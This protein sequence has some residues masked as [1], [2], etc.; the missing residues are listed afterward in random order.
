MLLALVRREPVHAASHL[1]QPRQLA[2]GARGEPRAR[3][4]GARCARRGHGAAGAADADRER[5]ARNDRR[6]GGRV[7]GAVAFPLLSVLVPSTLP[8]ASQPTLDLRVLGWR[9]CSRRSPALGFGLIPALRT[10]GRA[11]IDAL[12]A[13]ALRRRSSDNGAVLLVPSKSRCRSYCSSLPG[14]LIRAYAARAGRRSWLQD[15]A[16]VLTLR[17]VLPKPKYDSAYTR[18]QFYSAVLARCGGCRACRARRTPA[19]LPMVM[20]GGII[21]RVITPGQEVQR[22]RRLPG[23]PSLRD[24]AVLSARLGIP[25]HEGP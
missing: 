13:G 18:E 8:L 10:G 2:A 23:E 17:T 20:T 9:R 14:L 6:R 7:R 25:L 4:G 12:R 3:A 22:D 5:G 15:R 21:G 1:R 16:D 19:V 24:T 11:A